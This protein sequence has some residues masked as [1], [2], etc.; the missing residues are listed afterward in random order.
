MLSLASRNMK[1]IYRDRLSVTLGLAMPA[2][3]LLLFSS[4]SDNMPVD[5]FQL[6][7]LTPGV[8]VFSFAFLMMFSSVLLAKD[9]DSSFINRLLASPLN[10][11]DFVLAYCL[12]FVPLA[13]MQTAFCLIVAWL[14]GMTL[15]WQIFG[16]FLLATIPISLVFIGLGM[17]FGSLFSENQVPGF[18]SLVIVVASLFGGAWMNLH[19]VGGLFEKIGYALPFAHATDTLRALYNNL[20]WADFATNVYT[21]LGY[22][23]GLILIGMLALRWRL[24]P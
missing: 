16:W 4:L 9:R 6:H 7:V 2:I 18:G 14:L 22:A 12:P 23:L 11:A 3:L 15:T 8:I 13:M 10:S 21:T 17:I 5:I 24:K 19:Q 1:E 20:P